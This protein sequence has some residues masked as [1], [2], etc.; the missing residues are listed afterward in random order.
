MQILCSF[1]RDHCHICYSA[2]LNM[3]RINYEV[4]LL[5]KTESVADVGEVV[6][7]DCIPL[8]PAPEI[9][10]QPMWKVTNRMPSLCASS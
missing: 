2:L 9:R 7:C 8:Q 6:W 4:P 3:F 10:G 5:R 1:S